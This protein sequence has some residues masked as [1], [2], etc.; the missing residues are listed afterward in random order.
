MGTIAYTGCLRLT[1]LTPPSTGIPGPFAEV[2]ELVDALDSGSSGRLAVGVQ[3]PPSAP[4]LGHREADDPFLVGKHEPRHK[5]R[6]S[7]VCFDHML[8]TIERHEPIVE[9]GTV[10]ADT[11]TTHPEED[12]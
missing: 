6:C 3:V 11:R 10:V 8:L 12:T 5:C 7:T 9:V 1:D 4:H 2:A